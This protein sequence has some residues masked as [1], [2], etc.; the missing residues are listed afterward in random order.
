MGLWFE[1]TDLRADK[2]LRRSAAAAVLLAACFACSTV[3][4]GELAGPWQ[5]GHNVRSRLIAGTIAAAPGI[6]VLE[7]GQPLAGLEIEMAKGWKT[8]W[9]N[10][11]DAGG[12]PPY[13]TFEGSDN[14]KSAELLFPAP[15]RL[16]D[17]SG[18]AIGYK[19]KV[20]F[21]IAVAPVDATRPVILKVRIEYGICREIC[22]PAEADHQ[23]GLPA[24]GGTALPPTLAAALARVPRTGTGA[25]LPSIVETRTSAST[26]EVLAHYPAGTA[27]ADLFVEAP[28]GA[29]VPLPKRVAAPSPERVRYAISLG[30]EQEAAAL[31]GKTLM[32]TLVGPKASATHPIKV[33]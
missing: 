33:H 4:A 8:Y 12:V 17:A 16:A 23:I 27:G 21:P 10:P 15:A 31:K 32:L 14:L 22:I 5:D 7:A 30:T 13:V 28:D 1:A 11:G 3:A 19:E 6:A 24:G 29:Y 26:I 18:E 20:I 25:D 2:K 9:R